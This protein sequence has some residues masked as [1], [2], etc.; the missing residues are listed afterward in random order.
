ME[1]HC[2]INQ[3]FY[4]SCVSLCALECVSVLP[5]SVWRTVVFAQISATLLPMGTSENLARSSWKGG[6]Y[7]S[8]PP[9]EHVP[10]W[11]SMSEAQWECDFWGQ[12]R[13]GNFDLPC[14]RTLALSRWSPLR[15]L[16]TLRLTC[17]EITWRKRGGGRERGRVAHLFQHPAVW[18]SPAWALNLSQRLSNVTSVGSQLPPR[19]DSNQFKTSDKNCLAKPSGPP[20]L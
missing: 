10:T 7:V 4:L 11:Q 20:D 13:W 5:K 12:K 1:F 16:V 3:E 15:S 17:A 14:L 18:T 6:V 2:T 9:K 8:S 19:I